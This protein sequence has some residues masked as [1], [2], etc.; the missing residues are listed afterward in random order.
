MYA[1]WMIIGGQDPVGTP[2]S[3]TEIINNA[4]AYAYA[5]W[6]GICWLLDCNDCA[7]AAV[8]QPGY[9]Y[10]SPIADTAPW[11]EEGNADSYGFLG[12]IGLDVQGAEDS[13]RQASVTMGTSGSGVI[14][15]TYMGPREMVVRAL[16]IA[17]DECSLQYGIQWLRGQYTAQVNANP[18]GGDVL[19]FFDCCPCTCGDDSPGDTCWAND[20]FELKNDP[21]CLTEWWWPTSY[22][23]ESSG[24]PS[25]SGQWWPDT[26]A[27]ETTP[28]D[29]T[30]WWPSNYDEETHGD[31]GFWWPDTY[32]ELIVGPPET[33][34]EWCA[35]VER[36]GDLKAGPATWAC[37]ADACITPYMRQF[38]N[39]R[40]TEGPTMLSH[41][42]LNSQ[43]AVAEI[44]FTIVAADPAVH[45]M[46]ERGARAWVTGGLPVAEVAAAR[47]FVNPYRD[48]PRRAATLPAHVP[49]T[50]SWVRETVP[51]KRMTAQVLTGI[52]PRV[53]IRASERSGP[54]RL[55]LWAGPHRVGGYTIPFVAERSSVVVNGAQAYYATPGGYEPL[56]AFVRDW[57]GKWPTALELPHGDYH[58]TVDQA[59]DQAVRL[60]VDVTVAP[61]GS[62]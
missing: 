34:E 33:A 54:I 13:T 57:D 17:T 58:L 46:P 26:Y 51:I 16:M 53:R 36:Y 24:P 8:V 31:E 55:G 37:C 50:P 1:G 6:A 10:V 47:A 45:A 60:L 30:P 20:Y 32:G 3:Y 48:R 61:V 44:E 43:G 38:Y 23:E 62:A 21:A 18:C 52:E 2:G 29:E 11:Y 22:A 19:T 49:L 42:R 14:G 39:V 7:T 12:V 56:S 28:S 9:P 5:D 25:A 4:R 41:P 40:V 15:R 35:W 59:A 27:E